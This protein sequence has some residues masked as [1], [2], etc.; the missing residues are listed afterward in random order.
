MSWIFVKNALG[1]WFQQYPQNVSWSISYNILNITNNLSHLEQKNGSSQTV[2]IKSFVLLS[3]VGIKRVGCEIIRMPRNYFKTWAS[4]FS[5]PIPQKVHLS[6]TTTSFIA[7]LTGSKTESM[8]D[9]CVRTLKQKC[10]GY[11]KK[12]PF[13]GISLN[14]LYIFGI[15][16]KT[17]LYQKPCY[18]EK[19]YRGLWVTELSKITTSD[20]LEQHAL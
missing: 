12:W 10:V 15:Q 11:I 3:N 1:R 13:V 19:Y 9:N 16:L 5:N 14:N 20:I 8:L 6:Y 17:L 2:I 4:V 7:Q 18:N